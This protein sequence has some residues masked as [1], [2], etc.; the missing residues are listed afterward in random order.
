[1]ATLLAPAVSVQIT[2]PQPGAR[3]VVGG[4]YDITIKAASTEAAIVTILGSFAK[5]SLVPA[6]RSIKIV[7][8]SLTDTV[9]DTWTPTVAGNYTCQAQAVDEAGNLH[10]TAS[11]VAKV[12]PA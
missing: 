10:T 8:A 3:L 9:A 5:W 2:S 7:Q 1:M 11:F 6:E 4:T 12:L